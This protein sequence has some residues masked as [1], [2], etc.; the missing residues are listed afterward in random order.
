MM[1][2]S[3]QAHFYVTSTSILKKLQTQ[4]EPYLSPKGFNSRNLLVGKAWQKAVDGFLFDSGESDMRIEL[5]EQIG[6]QEENVRKKEEQAQQKA[7]KEK[8]K[9]SKTEQ[10]ACRSVHQP[11][12]EIAV[13]Q[14]ALSSCLFIEKVRIFLPITCDN[15][16][17]H[18]HISFWLT[19]SC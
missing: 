12:I 16:T 11:I 14:K 3:T 6:S 13:V 2:C 9:S 18:T 19:C 5:P 7:S 17:H 8:R 1:A 4:I 10:E 15:Y